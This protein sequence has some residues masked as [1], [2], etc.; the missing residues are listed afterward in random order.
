MGFPHPVFRT[1]H[2]LT[3]GTHKKSKYQK[4]AWPTDDMGQYWTDSLNKKGA[5][6]NNAEHKPQA[7]NI[8]T[9]HL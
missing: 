2:P 6:I 4:V 3:K 9:S 7:V 8:C 5:F 1:F